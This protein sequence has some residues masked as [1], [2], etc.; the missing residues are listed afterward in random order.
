M[1]E[2]MAWASMQDG[3]R[4]QGEGT[5]FLNANEKIHTFDVFCTR[6][7]HEVGHLAGASHSSDP[8]SVMYMFDEST[9]GRVEG[10]WDGDGDARCRDNGRPYLESRGLL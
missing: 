6:V 1:G 7:L 9:E 4:L 5:V 8:R 3:C 10:R 2:P